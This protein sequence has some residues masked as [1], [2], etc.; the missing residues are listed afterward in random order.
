MVVTTHDD[1]EVEL[2]ASPLVLNLVQVAKGQNHVASKTREVFHVDQYRI[3]WYN[4][5]PFTQFRDL[6]VRTARQGTFRALG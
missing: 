3:F 5:A 2:S 4:P 1:R 6:G